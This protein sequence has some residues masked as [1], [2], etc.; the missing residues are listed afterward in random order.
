[1]TPVP[2]PGWQVPVAMQPE[3]PFSGPPSTVTMNVLVLPVVLSVIGVAEAELATRN[4]AAAINRVVFFMRIFLPSLFRSDP[5]AGTHVSPRD[6]TFVRLPSL[7]VARRVPKRE[8]TH[9]SRQ[10]SGFLLEDGDLR[11]LRHIPEQAGG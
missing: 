2:T 11:Q 5:G 6:G 7:S 4:A 8:P 10:Q 9:A 1:M 3:G